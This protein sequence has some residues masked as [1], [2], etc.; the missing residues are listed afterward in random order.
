MSILDEIVQ[1]KIT[2]EIP[3]CKRK[4]S[5]GEMRNRAEHMP[6]PRDFN[7]AI[8]RKNGMVSLIAEVKRASPSKGELIKGEFDP[9]AIAQMYESNG[10]SAISVLTDK[11]YFKGHLSYLTKI[12]H[13]TTLPVLRKEFIV[14]PYQIYEA[15]AAYA[16]AILLIVAVL[17]DIMLT[18]FI[19]LA[20]DL[21]MSALVEAHDT[22]EVDRA[23]ACGA[24]IIGIN[25][26][27]LHTFKVDLDVTT[28]C[29]QHI[30]AQH[31]ST[32]AP[33]SQAINGN[34]SFVAESGIFTPAHVKRVANAGACAILVGE[35]IITANNAAEQ[36]RLLSNIKA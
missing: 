20:H 13:A 29:A 36:V 1:H 24:K 7:A 6:Q 26:R 14:D 28:R 9:V 15:R 10:A 3:A 33:A 27:D 31:I 2:T 22:A 4:C 21:N 32:C 12:K 18:E 11:K 19:A 5:L 34:I 25:N 23:L 30:H 35:S 17:D 8:N 16:D